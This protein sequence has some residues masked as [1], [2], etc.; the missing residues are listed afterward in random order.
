M[1]CYSDVLLCKILMWSQVRL[2][3]ISFHNVL[4]EITL[5]IFS[6]LQ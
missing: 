5:L 1:L 6:K 4:K 2:I 3:A